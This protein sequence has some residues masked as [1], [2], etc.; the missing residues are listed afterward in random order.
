MKVAFGATLL[1]RGLNNAKQDGIDGIG[2]YCQELLQHFPSLPDAPQILP[3][4]FGQTKTQCGATLLPKYPRHALG[5]LSRLEV[6]PF[7]IEGIA[8]VMNSNK[9]ENGGKYEKNN[10]K[11]MEDPTLIQDAIF[12]HVLELFKGNEIDS[13]SGLSHLYHIG[14]NAMMLNWLLTNKKQK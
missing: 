3:Y 7:F 9:I 11:K 6:D 5:A 12:R 14:A 4:A 2:Q 8:N 1:D 10:W 13:Q